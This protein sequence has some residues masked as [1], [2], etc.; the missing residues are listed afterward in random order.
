MSMGGDASDFV[1]KDAATIKFNDAD[2]NP[3][4]AK[5]PAPQGYTSTM[6]EVTLGDVAVKKGENTFSITFGD[7]TPS[8]DCFKL[9]VK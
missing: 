6:S 3:G 1:F 5:F 7:S 9:S 2:Y 4:E 8:L